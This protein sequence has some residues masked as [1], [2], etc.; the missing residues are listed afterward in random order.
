MHRGKYLQIKL[1]YHDPPTFSTDNSNYYHWQQ[2]YDEFVNNADSCN[3]TSQAGVVSYDGAHAEFGFMNNPA[4]SY[5]DTSKAGPG[6]PYGGDV[7]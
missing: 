6:V 5:N 4:D 7:H 1:H 2:C 3:D